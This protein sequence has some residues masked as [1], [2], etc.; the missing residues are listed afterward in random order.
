MIEV[1]IPWRLYYPDHFEDNGRQ[2]VK[3][4]EL[5]TWIRK[6]CKAS[7]KF[8][9]RCRDYTE[10]ERVRRPSR[11]GGGKICELFAQFEREEDVVLF[12]LFWL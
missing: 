7:V 2:Y 6:T 4:R 9:E 11:R 1:K 8:S 12:K 3:N 5:L 10:E